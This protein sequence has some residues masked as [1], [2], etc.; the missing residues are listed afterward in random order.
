MFSRLSIPTPFQVGPVNAYLAGR[1]IVDPGPDSDE[2]WDALTEGL[3]ARDLAPGDLD[4]ALITHP[5]PD[6][7]GAAKRLREAGVEVLAAPA[8]AQIVGA[9]EDRLEYEQ[10]YFSE[11]FAAHGMSESTA[12]TVVDLPQAYLPYAPDCEIDRTL[13]DGETLEVADDTITAEAVEG[14]AAGELLFTFEAAGGERAIVGDHVLGEVTP[15]PLLQPP[16]EQGGE[17]PRVLP[18]YNDSLETLRTREFDQF[19][20]GHGDRIDDPLGRIDEM[21]AA[22]EDRTENVRALVEEP[23]TATA[24]MEGLFDDL[25]VT[26]Y[27]PAMSE[28]IGHLDVLEARGAVAS[29]EDEDG[30]VRYEA[31]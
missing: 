6:H 13:A 8:T 22:H 23:I 3:A 20:P 4:R 7:F 24:V 1:T 29:F 18:A 25:P 10:S 19:L 11:L 21:L 9:F 15:N 14:H 12:S 26:E 27:F 16:A 5:H 30:L 31:A 28:A 2:S 17:R